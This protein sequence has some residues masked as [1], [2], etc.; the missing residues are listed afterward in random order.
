MRIPGIFG[1]HC[2]T[3]S[4]PNHITNGMYGMLPIEPE[5]GLPQVDR[6]F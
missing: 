6:E 1:Y 4:V 5:R 2:A 3:P